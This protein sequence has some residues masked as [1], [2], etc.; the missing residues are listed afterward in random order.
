ML[1][2]GIAFVE[3]GAGISGLAGCFYA[4]GH[5]WMWSTGFLRIFEHFQRIDFHSGKTA[6]DGYQIS[7][8]T[9]SSQEPSR[10]M[11]VCVLAIAFGL[12]YTICTQLWS[13]AEW[14]CKAIYSFPD[15][16]KTLNATLPRGHNLP[17]QTAV[18]GVFCECKDRQFIMG[19]TD[20]AVKECHDP[21]HLLSLATN[22]RFLKENL[23]LIDKDAKRFQSGTLSCRYAQMS[24]FG[25]PGIP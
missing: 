5:C 12:R 13:N 8:C 18:A 3:V 17:G 9:T 1:F 25:S 23:E 6:A 19:S 10:F 15:I 7:E 24:R 4:I 14:N 16:H 11:K 22:K 21:D 2:R 20:W